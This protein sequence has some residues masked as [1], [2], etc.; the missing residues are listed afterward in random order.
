MLGCALASPSA[1]YEAFKRDALHHLRIVICELP[2]ADL[3]SHVRRTILCLQFMNE[4][5]ED[6]KITGWIARLQDLY[7]RP[8]HPSVV[9]RT[10]MQVLSQIIGHSP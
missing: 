6:A 7:K 5:C 3:R 1:D 2:I 4:E 10:A 9:R 8:L